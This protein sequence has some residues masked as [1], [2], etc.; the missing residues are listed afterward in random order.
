MPQTNRI[1]VFFRHIKQ[2]E[3]FYSP[4]HAREFIKCAPTLARDTSYPQAVLPF[5]EY[6]FTEIT[7]MYK[8]NDKF[9]FRKWPDL[10][11]RISYIYHNDHSLKYHLTRTD[12]GLDFCTASEEEISHE[13]IERI[14]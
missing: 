10:I 12:N 2:G 4:E 9:R 13:I 11:L 1:R 14:K 8:L 6:D 7:P 5:E 3:K